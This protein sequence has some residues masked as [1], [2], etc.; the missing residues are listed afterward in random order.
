MPFII[1]FLALFIAW[2]F[3]KKLRSGDFGTIRQKHILFWLVIVGVLFAT[4]IGRSP[5]IAGVL[6]GILGALKLFGVQLLRNFP[7]FSRILL[8]NF[9]N[10]GKGIH[11]FES[12]YI[13]LSF[14]ARQ[15][16][17]ELAIIGG[18]FKNRLITDLSESEKSLFEQELANDI[19]S[20]YLYRAYQLQGSFK[21][22]GQRKQEQ[23]YQADATKTHLPM[24]R[25]QA[26]EILGVSSNASRDEVRLAHKQL[27][28]KLHPDKGGN[29]Y[30]ASF[31]NQAKDKLLED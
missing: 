22:D 20:Q 6:A 23:Q 1:I 14:D 21:A 7:F 8:K 30:L 31:I 17:L 28:Q 16:R 25:H 5:A 11:Q 9:G 4:I 13:Q 19:K 18:Q 12:Q 15:R 27:M 10:A 2:V 29:A 26:A 3:F 24:D